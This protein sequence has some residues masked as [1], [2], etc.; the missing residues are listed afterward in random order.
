MLENV[1][2]RIFICQEENTMP[3]LK[4]VKNYLKLLLWCN[5]GRDLKAKQ[6]LA[7]TS[8]S[9]KAFEVSDRVFFVQQFEGQV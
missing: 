9:P 7:Y 6:L 3:G 8:D 2:T 5:T 4:D 1:P